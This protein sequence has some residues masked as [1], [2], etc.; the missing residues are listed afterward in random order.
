MFFAIEKAENHI[1]ESL[2]SYSNFLELIL[3]TESSE[4]SP[5]STSGLRL[6]F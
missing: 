2:F 6:Q 1:R 4:V 3:H 5:N